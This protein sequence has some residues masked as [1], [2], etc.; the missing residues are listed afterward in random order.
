MFTARFLFF[1]FR[2][3]FYWLL[4]CLYSFFLFRAVLLLAFVLPAFIFS[5]SGSTFIGFCTACIHFFYFGQYFYWLLYCLH[6]FFYI[7]AVL[8]LTFVLPAFIFLY[9]G[10]TFI[11][12]CTACIYFFIFWQYFF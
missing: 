10:S 4:Y 8:L 5:I 9:S 12:F 6:L 7:L 1:S 2:Q 3:Y 11:D